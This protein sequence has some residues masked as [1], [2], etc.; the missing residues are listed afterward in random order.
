MLLHIGPGT[1]A[2]SAA[3]L[4]IFLLQGVE[5]KHDFSAQETA[6]Q[7][8]DRFTRE[9][10]KQELFIRME[11]ENWTGS[12]KMRAPPPS[13]NNLQAAC[14]VCARGTNLELLRYRTSSRGWCQVNRK[15]WFWVHRT[16]AGHQTAR[17]E[18][19]PTEYPTKDKQAGRQLRGGR[20]R[21][22]VWVRNGE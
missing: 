22:S 7:Q 21:L 11:K 8:H 4:N 12:E 17:N 14:A 15:D 3:Y 18:I 19:S 16:A 6:K 5:N 1:A 2:V 20:G 13:S 10:I 9:P